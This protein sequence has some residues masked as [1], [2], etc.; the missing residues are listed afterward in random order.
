M[1]LF[2][3][4]KNDREYNFSNIDFFQVLD[5][6]MYEEYSAKQM[7]SSGNPINGNYYEEYGNVTLE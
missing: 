6:M 5:H 1:P 2:S 7:L 4:M 3:R